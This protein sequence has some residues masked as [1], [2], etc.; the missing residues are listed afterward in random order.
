MCCAGRSV[1]NIV[2]RCCK[3]NSFPGW[4]IPSCPKVRTLVLDSN[5]SPSPKL[6]PRDCATPSQ[7]TLSSRL[8]PVT[9]LWP[10]IRFVSS[11]GKLT[12]SEFPCG[13]TSINVGTRTG[14]GWRID[15]SASAIGGI[16]GKGSNLESAVAEAF[17]AL[18]RQPTQA[19][20]KR[21]RMHKYRIDAQNHLD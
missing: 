3:M 6:S 2:T 16:I 14:T 9:I 15:G 13:T 19:A 8:M 4:G 7:D 5:A 11:I 17:D 21:T 12:I 18:E 10:T 1:S 20:A